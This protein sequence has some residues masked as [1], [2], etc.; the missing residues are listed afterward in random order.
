MVIKDDCFP[1]V[2]C[3]TISRLSQQYLIIASNPFPLPARPSVKLNSRGKY[4]VVYLN[5]NM[6]FRLLL[7]RTR[8][9]HSFTY[10]LN[11][12]VDGC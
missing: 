9:P 10:T 4:S 11:Q 5:R 3:Y 8:I 12:I 7:A 1:R 6:F 2:L